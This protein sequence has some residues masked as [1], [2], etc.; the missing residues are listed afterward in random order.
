MAEER[1]GNEQYNK[2]LE[3]VEK[4]S[5]SIINLLAR[6]GGTREKTKFSSRIDLWNK[7]DGIRKDAGIDANA[8]YT[9]TA[10]QNT[11]MLNYIKNRIR[12]NKELF[13][14]NT[15]EFTSL[16]G[17]RVALRAEVGKPAAAPK[18]E[19]EGVVEERVEEKTRWDTMKEDGEKRDDAYL[20][21]AKKDLEVF[22][23]ATHSPDKLKEDLKNQKATL[24]ADVVQ[25][26]VKEKTNANWIHINAAGRDAAYKHASALNLGVDDLKSS[27]KG[28][29]L[30]LEDIYK[31]MGY[32]KIPQMVDTLVDANFRG[33]GYKMFL[34]MYIRAED[35][36]AKA[37]I[38]KAPAEEIAKKELAI[39][40]AQEGMKKDL[41]AFEK[42]R[43]TMEKI[44]TAI[45][46]GK[47]L[48]Q[49]MGNKDLFFMN[50]QEALAD[51][52]EKID[53]E[54]KKTL[55][56]VGSIFPRESQGPVIEDTKRVLTMLEVGQHTFTKDTDYF[57]R[58][59][60][61]GA[62]YDEVENAVLDAGSSEK[63]R[64]N[65]V[66]ILNQYIQ[67]ALSRAG[68]SSE[69]EGKKITTE[70]IKS[71]TIDKNT[72]SLIRLGYIVGLQTTYALEKARRLELAKEY[73]K[74]PQIIELLRE[75][76]K[77][78]PGI[79][80]QELHRIGR[81][82]DL[83]LSGGIMLGVTEKN[84]SFGPAV[85]GF[86]SFDVGGGRSLSIGVTG[87]LD[88]E[89]GKPI[90]NIFNVGASQKIK[91]TKDTKVTMSLGLSALP[92]IGVGGSVSVETPITDTMDFVGGVGVGFELTT[93]RFGVGG[94]VGIHRNAERTL[95]KDIEK[96]YEKAGIADIENAKDPYDALMKHPVLGKKI[97]D[98]LTVIEDHMKSKGKTL[99]AEYK[100]VIALEIYDTIR[101]EI[102]AEAIA[103]FNPGTVTGAGLMLSA[104][105][106][107]VMPYITIAFGKK[108]RVL[109]LIDA[110]TAEISD[111]ELRKE[112]DKTL[113][114]SGKY[115]NLGASG[116][117]S[118]DENG[119]NDII[120]DET[121]K[122]E[123]RKGD[124][125]E[126]LNRAVTRA[127]VRFENNTD[128]LLKM[129]IEYSRNANINI[130]LD[131]EFKK[132]QLIHDAKDFYLNFDLKENLLVTRKEYRYPYKKEGAYRE[133]HIYIKK[134][135]VGESTLE[136]TETAF[137]ERNV[138]N[139]IKEAG[140]KGVMA[141]NNILDYQTFLKLQGEGKI[142]RFEIPSEK[143][144]ED[145]LKKL[146]GNGIVSAHLEGREVTSRDNLEKLTKDF[147]GTNKK[148]QT[149][150]KKMTTEYN[151]T[152]EVDYKVVLSDFEAYLKEKGEKPLTKL[153]RTFF[154]NILVE[155]TF[156]DMTN[157]TP[158]ERAD[159]L[160][161]EL[162]WIKQTFMSYLD[163]TSYKGDK[164][165]LAEIVMAH[166]EKTTFD[167]DE[168]VTIDPGTTGN[169]FVSMVGTEKIV[170]ARRS[171]DY[172]GK[173]F[174]LINPKE[175]KILST[176][177]EEHEIA[178]ALLEVVSP[179]DTSSPQA[180]LRSPL[181]LKLSPLIPFAFS[182]ADADLYLDL[183]N[184]MN[185]NHDEKHRIFYEKYSKMVIRVRESEKNRNTGL[186][187]GA[188]YNNASV[189][190]DISSTVGLF[191]KC[192]NFT[193]IG[194]E[195]LR[196]KVPNNHP[197]YGSA[198][199][200]THVRVG[201]R[202]QA[203]Y[204]EV[205]LA[206]GFFPTGV[207]EKTVGGGGGGKKPEEPGKTTTE[208]DTAGQVGTTVG[209]GKQGE[210]KAGPSAPAADI[211]VEDTA[212]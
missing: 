54:T 34:K 85:G 155:L 5:H 124:N 36:L 196:L 1:G 73:S 210:T 199:A 191:E 11:A 69:Y 60:S 80:D 48:I 41:P 145:A 21:K 184:G 26:W 161:R 119:R 71:G 15:Y 148:H 64:E 134:D 206:L 177:K 83:R 51:A 201:S 4:T 197:V 3:A 165:K 24:D 28:G 112:L 130:H 79:S 22:S 10:E 149:L 87:I 136:G 100:R 195:N 157:R 133:I 208:P 167:K 94:V 16:T 127:K 129:N 182:P 181:A 111:E 55:E 158:K 59:S 42:E 37:K 102:D 140:N 93:L 23:G 44:S 123:A 39:K 65:A 211:N 138:G 194:K 207:S 47:K 168:W 38:A 154:R 13:N 159:T 66:K 186:N 152:L 72:Q 33:S 153:E 108:T 106:L 122:F 162:K 205:G 84:G 115:I 212:L 107:P 99:S 98:I 57:E 139:A 56:F 81:R 178:A 62:A 43:P 82:I 185:P 114:E 203:S 40:E 97:N 86:L 14:A 121:T 88:A 78:N 204:K 174:K 53:P 103:D 61:Y 63:T 58:H 163:T 6:L 141:N 176:N 67:L 105:I 173:R 142:E 9:G 200:E 192:Q 190:Y 8:K 91:I 46:S 179:L 202:L 164:E 75:Y 70:T 143:A 137:L 120:Y 25:Q 132:T 198:S 113:G 104:S 68:K 170:G 118:M 151:P 171:N 17:E 74:Y 19:G 209:D 172:D 147:Y 110:S 18:T 77:A 183:M 150:L 32:Q 50:K 7:Y 175:F 89:T 31:K 144:Y 95:A 92:G 90:A 29:T 187:L 49:T 20:A 135:A 2:A 169:L 35:E 166:V 12:N 76:K 117:V 30:S 126:T 27:V 189:S 52:E 160:K 45:T 109:R 128:G 131:P 193:I 180:L 96:K 116:R 146:K 156:R 188:E 125:L 101:E